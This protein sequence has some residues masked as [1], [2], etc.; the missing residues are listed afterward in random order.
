MQAIEEQQMYP[1]TMIAVYFPEDADRRNKFLEMYRIEK[2]VNNKREEYSY[3]ENL[4][5]ESNITLMVK[6]PN[7]VIK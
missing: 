5:H 3:Y 6:L 2:V 4:C 7:G 1:K